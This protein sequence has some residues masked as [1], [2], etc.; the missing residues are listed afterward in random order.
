MG[1]DQVGLVDL[2]VADE[3]DVDVEGAGAPPLARDPARLVLQP[4]GDLE[5]LARRSIRLHGDDGVEVLRLLGS[6]DRVRRVDGRHRHDRD[7]V[8]G[9]EPVDRR[10]QGGG[11]V[12]DVGA[13]A[14]V[15][16]PQRGTSTGADPVPA[17]E[18]VGVEVGE[19]VADAK[20]QVLGGGDVGPDRDG[21]HDRSL[22]AVTDAHDHRAAVVVGARVV[23]LFD[24]LDRD[25]EPV[26]GAHGYRS[27]RTAT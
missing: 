23:T 24:G 16:A 27:M 13:E 15:R 18:G 10:L 3:E 11:A 8:G 19:V 7:A 14:E 17:R 26:S 22:F 6:A 21:A 5:E 12:A 20:P 2:V 25:D 1:N 4:L 9:G